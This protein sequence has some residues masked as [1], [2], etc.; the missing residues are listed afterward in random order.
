M[1]TGN[2]RDLRGLSP[3]DRSRFGRALWLFGDSL[4]RGQVLGKFPDAMTDEQA[5]KEPLWPFR[6]P[7]AM[8]NLFV[9]DTNSLTFDE[10]GAPVEGDYVAESGGWTGSRTGQTRE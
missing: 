1:K 5:D 7:P 8:I 9:S 4:F 2:S 3:A 10:M 6:S